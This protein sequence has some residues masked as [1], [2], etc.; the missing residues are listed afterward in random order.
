MELKFGNYFLFGD[1]GWT[2]GW[3]SW[4][5]V[6]TQ[7]KTST[8]GPLVPFVPSNTLIWSILHWTALDIESTWPRG[9]SGP[10][11]PLRASTTPLYWAGLEKCSASECGFPL[12]W[13][14]PQAS[15][16][17]AWVPHKR[18]ASAR[19][20]LDLPGG[21]SSAASYRVTPPGVPVTNDLESQFKANT[22]RTRPL[23]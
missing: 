20:V 5:R 2:F 15:T 1:F 18:L 23:T 10:A 8:L 21:S 11:P 7:T 12:S 22:K 9:A 4:T 6:Q 17:S 14:V 13:S 16:P 19:H 3:V